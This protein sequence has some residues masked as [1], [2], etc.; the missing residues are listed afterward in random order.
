MI[1]AV[2][3]F[4]GAGGLTYGLAE[5]GVSVRLGIDLDPACEYP[6]TANNDAA[7]MLGSVSDLSGEQ[8]IDEL[9]TDTGYSLLAGCA[10]CQ[11][12]STYNQRADS[13]DQRWFLLLEFLRLIGETTPDLVTMENVPGLA[14]QDVFKS[15]LEGLN[16]Q[17]YYVDYRVVNC[18]DYGLPQNRNR[19]VLVA[20]QLSE[21]RLLPPEHFNAVAR[22]V[23]DAIGTLPALKAGQSNKHDPLHKAA[24]LSPINQAR[25]KASKPGGTWLDWPEELR[26]PCHRK[27]SGST[28]R[29]VYGR[30]RW[31]TP[32][33]TLT[34]Q[35]YGFGS[36]RFGHP[37]Q[38][39]ALSLRE[40][41]ILQG[42]PETYRF[43]ESDE[44]NFSTIARLIGNAVPVTLGTVIGVTLKE[45]IK[46][47]RKSRV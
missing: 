39:R 7:F 27:Q 28:Y 34:T 37:E 25:I 4:C 24:S 14:N 2:D 44:Y 47:A 1:N 18:A 5:A 8:I 30:M 33:P 23:K 29:S 15:F 38:D 32:S 31:D 46:A 20:S 6:Y 22:S 10:P 41:A 26:A 13:S 40:G 16:K 3:L 45:H 17:G 36:G 19:L 35:F 43:T 9:K 21:I 11:T 42:F 12:F